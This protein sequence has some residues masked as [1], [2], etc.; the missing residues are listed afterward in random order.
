MN[1]RGLL[2]TVRGVR[3]RKGEREREKKRLAPNGV[4]VIKQTLFAT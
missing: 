3:G 4:A 1:R 2:S